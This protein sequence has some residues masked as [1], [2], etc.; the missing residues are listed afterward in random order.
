MKTTTAAGGAGVDE[1]DDK[2]PQFAYT[3]ARGLEVLRAFDGDE[4]VLGN[5]ELAER[6]GIPRPTVARLTRTLAQLGYLRYDARTARYRMSAAMLCL[7]HPLLAQLN[8][9]QVARP[10]MQ[11]L[12]DFAHGSVALAMRHGLDMV[13]IE[14]CIDNNAITARPD[15][16]VRRELVTTALGRAYLAAADD[17]E[18]KALLAE[19]RACGR[20]DWKQFKADLDREMARFEAHGYCVAR[21]TSR[22]GMHAVAVPL[23]KAF[24][25]EVLVVNCTVASFQLQEGTLEGVIAPRL[26][27]LAQSVSMALGRR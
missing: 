14:S 10:L 7:A 6:T 21:D 2:D 12:A 11:Q 27:N 8:V 1:S 16:G 15:I 22:K 3:L 4:P 20:Y 17:E 24:E 25:G 18:R 5:R 9:R 26:V 19:I 13:L 23:R